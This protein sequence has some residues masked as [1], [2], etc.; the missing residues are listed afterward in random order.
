MVYRDYF[1]ENLMILSRPGL[2]ALGL[3][4]FQD[5]VAGPITYDL[6]SLLEDARRDLPH[7]LVDSMRARYI[8][9]FPALDAEAFAAS[10]AAMAAHRHIKCLGLF[11]RLAKRDGKPAYLVHIPRLWRLLDRSL[12]H[13][14]LG[15]LA[16][17]LDTHVP[18]ARR[19]VPSS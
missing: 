12:S 1:A 4:D 15:P 9:A 3:L 18:A 7:A 14:A 6:A 13:P 2:A 5:A 17:W 16:G 8:A 10:W 19:V 11:V